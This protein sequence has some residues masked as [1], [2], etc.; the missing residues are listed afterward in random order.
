M[1]YVGRRL[2]PM[3]ESGDFLAR[4]RNRSLIGVAVLVGSLFLGAAGYH[5]TEHIPWLDATLNASMLLAGEGPI[6][7]LHSAAG[8]VFATFY[9]LF[10]GIAFVTA[11][12]VVGAPVL[13]RFLHHVHLDIT[14]DVEAPPPRTPRD[15]I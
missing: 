3:S 11:V 12:S 5:V 14:E 4:L 2:K 1:S 10:S 7:P 13:H 6:A 9:A 8:K 15:G